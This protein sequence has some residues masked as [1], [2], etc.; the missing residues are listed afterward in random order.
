MTLR[1][2]GAVLLSTAI[3]GVALGFSAMAQE[4]NRNVWQG[5]YTDGQAARG[6]ELYRKNCGHCHRDDLT[7]G[8]SEAGAPPLSGPIFFYRWLHS[9]VADMFLTI[10]TTMPQNNPDSLTPQTVV[11][12]VSFLLAQN[13]MPA[14]T[15]ELPPDVEALQKIFVT[16]KATR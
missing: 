7:G 13:E 11:D 16:E 12:I 5:V 14:G 2:R 10:G 6:Q 15:T 8:G 4:P 9:P 3:A 1:A